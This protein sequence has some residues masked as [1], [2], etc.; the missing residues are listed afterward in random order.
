MDAAGI[1]PTMQNTGKTGFSKQSGAECGAVGA[2]NTA[3]DPDLVTVI[4]RWP[5]LSEEVRRGIVA[6][7]R[8]SK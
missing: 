6:M 5:T 4:E 1:E 7:V 3:M 8:A 2:Q